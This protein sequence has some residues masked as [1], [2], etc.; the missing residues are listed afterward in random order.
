MSRILD[1]INPDDL[2]VLMNARIVEAH[3]LGSFLAVCGGEKY[4]FHARADEAREWI[5]D[6][7]DQDVTLNL[8]EF[9]WT[10]VDKPG[11]I[12][13]RSGVS[14]LFVNGATPPQ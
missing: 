12:A 4:R 10:L 8:I 9:H 13:E 3:P 1:N 5:K 14:L 6:H 7:M 11:P 2:T